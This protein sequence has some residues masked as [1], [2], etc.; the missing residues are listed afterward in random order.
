MAVEVAKILVKD[1]DLLRDVLETAG[2]N[3]SIGVEIMQQLK[4]VKEKKKLD[5]EMNV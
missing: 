1:S 2:G 5:K 4:A 3:K